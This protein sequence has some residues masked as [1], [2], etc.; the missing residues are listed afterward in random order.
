MKFIT[1]LLISLLLSVWNDAAI[2]ADSVIYKID[3][4]YAKF[5]IPLENKDS[6]E[7]F[8]P[9]TQDGSLE[10]AVA[11]NIGSSQAGY[12]LY[13]YPGF[14]KVEGP[15]KK[16]LERGQKSVWVNDENSEVISSHH[17]VDV[18]Y[19]EP[20]FIVSITNPRTLRLL[21]DLDQVSIFIRGFGSSA[22]NL[23][24]NIK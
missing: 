19:S 4:E 8:K 13:K 7:W 18:F 5:Y 2:A 11:V 24:V 20:Y 22:N 10:Y 15:I 6:Y 1:A 23:V 14:A 17:S 12:F 16:L 3:T 9:E 21:E